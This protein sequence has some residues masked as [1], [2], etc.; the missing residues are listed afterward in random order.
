MLLIIILTSSV[1]Q[2][3]YPIHIGNTRFVKFAFFKICLT[4]FIAGIFSLGPDIR[5]CVNWI[6]DI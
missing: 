3:A 2:D 4:L 1:S 6:M 5:L